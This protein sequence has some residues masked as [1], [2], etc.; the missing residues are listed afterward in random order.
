MPVR[1][2]PVAGPTELRTAIGLVAQAWRVAYAEFLPSSS[3]PDAGAAGGGEPGLDD[4]ELRRR[5]RRYATRDDEGYLV[6]VDGD[7]VVGLASAIWNPNETKPFVA[8]DDA[9]LRSIYVRPDRWGEGIGSRLLRAV[10]D[11]LPPTV[12]GLTLETFSE[13]TPA[14]AFYEARGFRA[15]TTSTFEPDGAAVPTTVYRRGV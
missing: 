14:C 5:T 2:R 15:L 10:D 7:E 3:M 11:A 1:V 6:A 9:E 12:A 8:A 13:Y 4:E